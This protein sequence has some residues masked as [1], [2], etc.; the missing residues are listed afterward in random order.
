M[1]LELFRYFSGTMNTRMHALISWIC[2]VI[3]VVVLFFTIRSMQNSD[4]ALMGNPQPM[5]SVD[6]QAKILENTVCGRWKVEQYQ[7]QLDDIF[8][9]CVYLC[10][11]DPTCEHS[12]H[13]RCMDE[14]KEQTDMLHAGMTK[15]ILESTGLAD[16]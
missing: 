7:D 14:V 16:D 3:S 12:V 2:L 8:S 11:R 15:C 10:L 9:S 1:I 5:A 13:Q 6:V 4:S